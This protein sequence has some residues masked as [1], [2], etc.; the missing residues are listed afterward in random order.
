MRSRFSTVCVVQCCWVFLGRTS[1]LW[2]TGTCSPECAAVLV[3]FVLFNVVGFFSDAPRPCGLQELAHLTAPP[4]QY[5]LC[6]SIFIFFCGV[7][8]IIVCLFALCVLLLY[9]LYFFELRLLITSQVFSNFSLYD[10]HFMLHISML[11]FM[12]NILAKHF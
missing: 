8:S 6:C 5:G 7:L 9:F 12:I 10:C 2:S 1:P 3:R 11:F 4:F